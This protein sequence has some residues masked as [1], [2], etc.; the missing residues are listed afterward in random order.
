[1]KWL[2]TES[3]L[4]VRGLGIG[5]RERNR[6]FSWIVI[7]L[8]LSSRVWGVEEL[9]FWLGG[10]EILYCASL[11]CIELVSGPYIWPSAAEKM[12]R[13]GEKVRNTLKHLGARKSSFSTKFAS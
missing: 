8:A 1:M 9:F 11:S 7:E 3:M 12:R 2:D 13:C 6:L 4:V 5:Y 10:S